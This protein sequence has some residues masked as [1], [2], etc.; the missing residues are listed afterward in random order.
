VAHLV[1]NANRNVPILG[2]ELDPNRMFSR[3]GAE[4]NLRTLN[5]A[6]PEAQ[7]QNALLMLDRKRYELLRAVWPHKGDVLI[8]LHNNVEYSVRDELDASN[9]VALNDEANPHEFC[10]ATN[11][12]DFA[13]LAKGP[14]NVVLQNR[15][16]GAEDGSLSRFA[17]REGFRY[18][19]IEVG[20]GRADRQR[21]I[22]E[23][24]DRTLPRG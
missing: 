15:P 7:I 8:A 23:W 17:A 4:R 11:E 12:N 19:N 3:E 24:V 13:L 22:L 21:E 14:Y 6:W 10:L 16:A 18:V 2:G 20:L 1:R 5:P 9:K